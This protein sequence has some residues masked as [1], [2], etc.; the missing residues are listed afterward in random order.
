MAF[1]FL[2]SALWLPPIECCRSYVGG[3]TDGHCWWSSVAMMSPRLTLDIVLLLLFSYTNGHE[4]G[5][6]NNITV[7]SEANRTHSPIH[8]IYNH[9]TKELTS[10][11][12]GLQTQEGNATQRE[13]RILQMMKALVEK[14]IL[15]NETSRSTNNSRLMHWDQKLWPRTLPFENR[16]KVNPE[17][18]ICGW[19]VIAK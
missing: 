9:G 16:T 6:W 13:N 3:R 4:T 1:R 10:T 12:D 15:A 19:R 17:A 7:Q 5:E 8:Y 2:L 18:G 11:T 14:T